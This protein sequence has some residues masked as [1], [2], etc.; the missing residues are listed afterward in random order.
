M[1][2][3]RITLHH[4]MTKL[5]SVSTKVL[6]IYTFINAFTNFN[7]RMHILS[8]LDCAQAGVLKTVQNLF[9]RC[10]ESRENVKIKVGIKLVEISILTI[11]NKIFSLHFLFWPTV[12]PPNNLSIFFTLPNVMSFSFKITRNQT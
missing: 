3:K 7:H 5:H 9:L 2:Y 10:V 1:I 4:I 6:P 8:F 11:S 12:P